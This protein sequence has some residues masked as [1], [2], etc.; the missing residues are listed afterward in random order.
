MHGRHKPFFPPTLFPGSQSAHLQRT[1]L[2]ARRRGSPAF[3]F[4]RS[5]KDTT[6]RARASLAID[7]NDTRIRAA[8]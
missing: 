1:A 8:H 5:H 2:A 6:A 3:C 4:S 7:T